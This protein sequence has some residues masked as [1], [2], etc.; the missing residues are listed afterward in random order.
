MQPYIVTSEDA[1]NIMMAIIEGNK[2]WNSDHISDFKQSLKAHYRAEQNEQCCYCKRVT[3]G[4][5]KMVLDIEHILPKGIR[6]FKKF[7]FEPKNL[8]VSCKRCNMEIKKNDISFITK[9][10]NFEDTFY[11]SDKY[12]FLH[13]H[14]DNYWD[15][16]KYSV[17]IENDILLIQYAIVDNCKKG[18]YTYNYFKLAQLEIDSV[19]EAQGIDTEDISPAIDADIALE[20]QMLLQ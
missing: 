4:E 7:M 6:Q 8:C 18:V 3:F 20:I 16:I 1:K 13:P 19:N 17:V 12:L 15:S 11:A 2:I 10:A 5:F 9:D 14:T